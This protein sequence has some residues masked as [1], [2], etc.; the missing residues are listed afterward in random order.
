[1]VVQSG[2]SVSVGSRTGDSCNPKLNYLVYF[3]RNHSPLKISQNSFFF[4]I[5]TSPV[6]DEFGEESIPQT[7]IPN[8]FPIAGIEYNVVALNHTPTIIAE[9]LEK[10]RERSS[11]SLAII[12]A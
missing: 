8:Y 11:A 3:E 7:L 6:L 1:M 9:K 12:N 2:I 5:P 10:F 4:S